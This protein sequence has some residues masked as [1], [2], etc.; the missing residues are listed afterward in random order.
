MSF[1]SGRAELPILFWEIVLGA[2]NFLKKREMDHAAA[3][4]SGLYLVKRPV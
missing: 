2:H 4:E 3:G 1:A